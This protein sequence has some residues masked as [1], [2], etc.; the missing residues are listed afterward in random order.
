MRCPSLLRGRALVPGRAASLAAGLLAL[1]CWA[2]PAR[3]D[4]KSALEDSALEGGVI[5]FQTERYDE[6]VQRLGPLVKPDGPGALR[7]R[8]NRSRARM[9]YAACLLE[10]KRDDEGT[11]QLEQLIRD[12]LQF[13]PDRAAFPGRII[14]RFSDVRARLT[15][16]IEEATRQQLIR[17]AEE[18]R[19]REEREAREAGRRDKIEQMARELEVRRANSR[20]LALI[21]F[22]VG[23]FQN[24]QPLIGWSLF[25]AETTL[26][27]TT[28]VTFVLVRNIEGQFGPSVRQGDAERIRDEVVQANRVAFGTFVGVAVLGVLHSQL[29]FV[30]EFRETK[31]RDLPP[32]VA[33]GLRGGTLRLTLTF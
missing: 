1:A 9:Y 28:A 13:F 5:Y 26:L 31:L 4:E 7:D 16:E 29:T 21:P 27:L 12:D 32:P 20:V 18:R 6:C 30:P 19:K 11:A 15:P 33:G 8:V 14:K 23:Q 2:A 17:E 10:L 3:A 24:R 22:G 25:A